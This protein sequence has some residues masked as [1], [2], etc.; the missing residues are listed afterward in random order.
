[1]KSNLHLPKSITSTNT[2]D[3]GPPYNTRATDGNNEAYEKAE[4][5]HIC[6]GLSDDVHS[7]LAS[8]LQ[9]SR[10]NGRRLIAAGGLQP[11]IWEPTEK[12]THLAQK[13]FGITELCE[14]I[15][16]HLTDLRDISA[17]MR[18]SRATIATARASM[19]LLQ[20]L[21]RTINV[22]DH[23]R[24]AFGSDQ[25]KVFYC[26]LLDPARN[27]ISEVFTVRAGFSMSRYHGSGVL[28]HIGTAFAATPICSP[29]IYEMQPVLGCCDAFSG[30]YAP[31]GNAPKPEPIKPV[32]NH[33]GITVGDLYT[34]TARLNEEHRLCPF[35][36]PCNLNVA[37]F[38]S[39]TVHFT[40]PHTFA[41]GDP[42]QFAMRERATAQRQ[43]D[44]QCYVDRETEATASEARIAIL[45][46]YTE[47][48]KHAFAW[49]RK[50]LTL[51]EYLADKTEAAEEADRIAK[52]SKCDLGGWRLDWD[53][54]N[55][56]GW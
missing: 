24:S 38:A 11:Q 53:S 21:G 31:Y 34:A 10:Y 40:A 4:R 27:D 5:L 20:S 39:P 12:S 43:Q 32:V 3:H 41:E 22:S 44:V 15:L 33:D 48:K 56:S 46:E 30:I 13:V 54:S 7:T 2:Q 51:E 18:V 25:D 42:M 35:A 52:I 45:E 55:G 1:M 14:Q 29:L 28:P 16:S 50:I 36:E 23:W 9:Q 26:E 19:T 47:A 17:A 6:N 37:G 49:Q 8:L